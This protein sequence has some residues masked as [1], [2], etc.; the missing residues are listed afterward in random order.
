MKKHY[1]SLMMAL[2]V[3][4]G[5]YYWYR[6]ANPAQLPLR[7]VT[8]PVEQGTLV[9]SVAGSGN[10][11]VNTIANVDPT[12]GGTVEN[13]SVS[14][15]DMVKKGQLLFTLVNDQLGVIASAGAE[16]YPLSASDQTVGP[17]E[18][19]QSATVE[20]VDGEAGQGSQDTGNSR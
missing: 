13:L 7:Y 4:I 12:I 10:I 5:G 16:R 9:T 14:Q 3:I 15:G 8:T 6:S 2:V 18:S 19:G 20:H 17:G 1:K 11:I